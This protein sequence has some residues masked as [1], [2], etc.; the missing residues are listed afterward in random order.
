M[1]KY[2]IFNLKTNSTCFELGVF[3]NRD[4]ALL[5]IRDLNLPNLTVSSSY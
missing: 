5:K 2:Y 1:K 3:L 4:T